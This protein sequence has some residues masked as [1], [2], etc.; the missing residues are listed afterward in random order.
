ML[1]CLCFCLA[2]MKWQL[3]KKK[4]VWPWTSTPC[5]GS[6]RCKTCSLVIRARVN[7]SFGGKKRYRWLIMAL[8]CG[9][10]LWID[11]RWKC[12]TKKRW[13]TK[14]DYIT[15]GCLQIIT[16]GAWYM[17][18]C[19]RAPSSNHFNPIIHQLKFSISQTNLYLNNWY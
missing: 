2:L 14:H 19:A 4:I 16:T 18:Y 15:L 3:K 7:R 10:P 8:G 13:L 6:M 11:Q 1:Y 17:G 9:P 12:I 5:Q